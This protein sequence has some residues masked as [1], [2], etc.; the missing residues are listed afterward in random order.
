[1]KLHEEY[2]LYETLWDDSV[3]TTTTI[4]EQLKQIKT[5]TDLFHFF[6]KAWDDCFVSETEL[7]E[8]F[9]AGLE[10][11]RLP[12]YFAQKYS[13][14]DLFYLDC[15]SNLGRDIKS[16]GLATVIAEHEAEAKIDGDNKLLEAK[17]DFINLYE[18]LSA[19]NE[20]YNIPYSGYVVV[21]E[22]G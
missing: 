11:K 21:Y 4:T 3:N 19:I 15:M 22:D 5:E 10:G 6:V 7:W 14:H 18:N 17:T 13:D 16:R 20:A 9:T 12:T 8:V 2:R 1:M